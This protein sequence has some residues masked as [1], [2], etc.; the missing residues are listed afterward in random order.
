M[1]LKRGDNVIM[2]GGKDR[3]KKGKVVLVSPESGTLVVEGLNL[4]KRHLRPRKQGQKGQIVNKERAISVSSVAL[5]C[6]SC[7]KPT[8]VGY[9]VEGVNKT[10][11]CKKCEAEV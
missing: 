7:G 1:K 2:L 8:R 11:I 9:K 10:R 5:I 4:V 3:G 6:K